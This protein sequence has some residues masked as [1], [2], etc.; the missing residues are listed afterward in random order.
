MK[1]WFQ[2]SRK[3]SV[4]SP[5]QLAGPAELLAAVEVHLRAG[6]AGPG[7]PGLPEVLRARQPHDPL[8]GDAD[9]AP[10]LDRLLVRPEA[11]LLVAL[12]DGHPDPLGIE[13]E[14][15]GRELPAPGD[16][17]LLEVVPEAPVAEHLE[18]GE[19]PR[20][21]ADLLDV[22]GAEAALARPRP[23]APAA[24]PCPR[25]YG[26]KGCIPAVVSSTEGSWTDGT[27]EAEGTI[28][29]PRS[30]KNER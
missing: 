14:A 22:G 25:K 21:V 10:D 23:A 16:R 3:R 24:S 17:L 7:G 28:L 12:E 4:S 9:P 13:A 30:S 2:Y 26:L 19:V 5:G 11:E 18:E 1:T 27:S 20:R 15:L 8:L 29:C 6:A